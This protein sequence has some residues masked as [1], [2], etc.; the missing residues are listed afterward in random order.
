MYVSRRS[1]RT[2]IDF[3]LKAHILVMEYA[4]F[5]LK[6]GTL[7]ENPY[8]SGFLDCLTYKIRCVHPSIHPSVCP[9][10]C[11]KVFLELAH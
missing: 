9:S 6:V 11:S 10:A 4:S 3:N 1:I 7:Y 8:C 2:L 5:N